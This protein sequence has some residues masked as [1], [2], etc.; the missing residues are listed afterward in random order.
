MFR[1]VRGRRYPIVDVERGV[2]LAIVHFDVPGRPAAPV[3]GGDVGT[4]LAT[5]P[6]TPLLYQLFKIEQGRIRE[7]Q[8]FMANARLGGS[9]GWER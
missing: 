3:S 5:T 8:A 9:N 2:V 4:V 6:R 1:R 7:V